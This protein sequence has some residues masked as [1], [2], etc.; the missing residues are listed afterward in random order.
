MAEANWDGGVQGMTPA[1][2]IPAL[3]EAQVRRVPRR[4]AIAAPGRTALTYA[5]LYAQV[6]QVVCTLNGMGL[7]RGDR[8]ATVLGNGPDMAVAFLA[9]AAAATCAPLNPDYRAEELDF[10][11]SDLKARAVIVQ[12]GVD[13]PARQ[14]A[15]GRGIPVIELCVPDGAGAGLFTLAGAAAWA[16]P[17]WPATF[18]EPDDIALALHTSGTTSRPKLVPLTQRN[19]CSSAFSIRRVLELTGTD[20]CLNVMPL[21]HIHG[22]IGAVLSSLAAG[23]EVVCARQAASH[24]GSSAGWRSFSRPGTPR[25]PPC[26]R[27]SWRGR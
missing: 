9:V 26:T 17:A 1:M 25:F 14:V 7:G 2:T 16:A 11:L 21:F 6:R 22:L 24:R 4:V 12:A 27:R 18:A 23:A 3:L 15:A 19:L 20:R 13:T 10:S 8:I 5:G